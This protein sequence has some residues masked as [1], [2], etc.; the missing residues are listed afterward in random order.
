[1]DVERAVLLHANEDDDELLNDG[2]QVEAEIQADDPLLME[3]ES[4]KYMYINIYEFL[5]IKMY[6]I[7]THNI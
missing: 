1:M 6:Y 4:G 2:N 3:E 5:L 7:Q